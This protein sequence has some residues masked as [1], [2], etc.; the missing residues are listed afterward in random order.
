MSN[1]FLKRVKTISKII[2][3]TAVVFSKI[4][5]PAQNIDNSCPVPS[6]NLIPFDQDDFD[7]ITHDAK[8]VGKAIKKIKGPSAEEQVDLDIKRHKEFAKADTEKSI[9]I[10]DAKTDNKIR[11]L[12]AKERIRQ[13][14]ANFNWEL[15][16]KKK[17]YAGSILGPSKSFADF[18]TQDTNDEQGARETKMLDVREVAFSDNTESPIVPG[19]IWENGL[20][21]IYGAQK[22]GKSFLGIQLSIDAVKGGRSSLFPKVDCSIPKCDVYFYASE[23]L[24]DSVKNRFPSNFFDEY[25]NYHLIIADHHCLRDVITDFNIISKGL[26]P[27]SHTLLIIDN[28]SNLAYNKVRSRDVD[29]FIETLDSYINNAKQLG[30]YLTVVLFAHANSKGDKPFA[31]NYIEKR[32]KAIIRFSGKK[33]ELRH[34]LITDMGTYFEK[35]EF[36]LKPV[37]VVGD[38]N[39]L[40]FIAVE[41]EKADYLDGTDH[42]KEGDEFIKQVDVRRKLTDEEI[43]VI[44]Q[45]KNAGERIEDI[46][47]E[48]GISMKTIYKW[49]KQYPKDKG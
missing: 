2:G 33:R 28:L 20:F 4:K 23:G 19:L 41:D 3:N 34:L 27:N 22:T 10:D 26:L 5:G 11:L 38:D 12:E 40:H 24:R 46:A 25:A 1:N 15:D 35:D 37:G 21:C 18:N 44:I 30:A 8:T 47:K 32:A 17:E 13:D 48:K 6:P 49:I 45:R 16:K 14:G 43:K 7:I 9:I 29:I 36:V 39:K 42:I 31:S